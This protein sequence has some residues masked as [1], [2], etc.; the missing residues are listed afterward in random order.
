V[1]ADRI[2]AFDAYV[3]DLRDLAD[4]HA[5]YRDEVA[6]ERPV[7]ALLQAAKRARAAES[8]AARSRLLLGLDCRYGQTRTETSVTSRS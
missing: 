5:A 6:A 3:S 8:R 4:A 1:P 7:E 2:E